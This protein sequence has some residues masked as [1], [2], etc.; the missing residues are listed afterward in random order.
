MTEL[1]IKIDS[2]LSDKITRANLVDC[3]ESTYHEIKMLECL[4]EDR[5]L[6]NHEKIDL[7]DAKAQKKSLEYVLRYISVKTDLEPFGLSHLCDW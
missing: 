7:Y 6:Q 2:D 4:M 1:T 5:D 3:L